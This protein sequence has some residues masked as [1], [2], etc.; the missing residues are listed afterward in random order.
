V[1]VAVI[2]VVI[3]AQQ[4]SNSVHSDESHKSVIGSFYVGDWQDVSNP[5]SVIQILPNGSASCRIV[6]GATN[7]TI[8][9]GQATFD[10]QTKRL[11]IKFFF[12]GPSWHVDEPPHQTPDGLV[13]KL[14][15]QIFRKSRSYSS[16]SG[17]QT[18]GVSI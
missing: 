17:N 6:H 12:V 16:P 7:Y 10:K 1:I 3:A 18:P 13:M 4:I 2:L 11:A 5:S 14:D 15:G 8:T 9:G